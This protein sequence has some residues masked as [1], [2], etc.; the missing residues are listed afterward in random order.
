M[1]GVSEEGKPSVFP[2]CMQDGVSTHPEARRP[3]GPMF[4]NGP[5][6]VGTVMSLKKSL[7]G[8][9]HLPARPGPVSDLGQ[10]SQEGQVYPVGMDTWL[11][12]ESR[13]GKNTETAL[14][15]K[16]VQ[17]WSPR[18]NKSVMVNGDPPIPKGQG[19]L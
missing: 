15:E 19:P 9:T 14:R 3:R 7:H 17:R 8:L 4:K 12:G 10:W 11:P 1:L 18:Q 13:K 2:L 16:Q 6:H 5:V